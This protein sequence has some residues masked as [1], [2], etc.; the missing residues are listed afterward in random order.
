MSS[1]SDSKLPVLSKFTL[2]ERGERV[3]V[4]PVWVLVHQE[5]PGGHARCA[6]L[7]AVPS[8]TLHCCCCQVLSVVATR[9]PPLWLEGLATRFQSRYLQLLIVVGTIHCPGCKA[10]QS[11]KVL[12]GLVLHCFALLCFAPGALSEGRQQHNSRAAVVLQTSDS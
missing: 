9:C 7:L 6:T 1:T 4:Q 3:E 10:K 12:L 2:E 5:H 11:L 8:A